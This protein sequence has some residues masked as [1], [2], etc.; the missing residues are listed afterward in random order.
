MES[1]VPIGMYIHRRANIYIYIYVYIKMDLDAYLSIHL[2]TYGW[3]S[4]LCSSLSLAD[5]D[6]EGTQKVGEHN[7]NDTLQGAQLT[8][9]QT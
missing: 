3:L 4:K 9:G 5:A 8:R 7:S 6:I 2:S 1:S